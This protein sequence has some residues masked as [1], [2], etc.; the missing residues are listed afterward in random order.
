MGI[1]TNMMNYLEASMRAEGTRQRVIANNI[2]NMNTPGFRRS[3]IDFQD[4]LSKAIG[5][6]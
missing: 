1:D 5:S 2:A 6:G 4:V 3:D